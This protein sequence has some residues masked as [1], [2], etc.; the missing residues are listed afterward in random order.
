MLQVAGTTNL[1]A[2]GELRL[3]LKWRGKVVT[4]EER[5]R[6]MK[7]E[8]QERDAKCKLGHETCAGLATCHCVALFA[9]GG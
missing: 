1:E 9:S 2:G 6:Q 3:S 7:V 8:E 5:G 4:K